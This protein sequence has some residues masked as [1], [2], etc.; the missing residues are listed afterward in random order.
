MYC[1][2]L[3]G[4]RKAVVLRRDRLAPY[5]PWA[6]AR[7]TCEQNSELLNTEGA[8]LK[9]TIFA[10]DQSPRSTQREANLPPLLRDFVVDV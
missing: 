8:S 1:V 10:Q 7:V 9:G 4:H 2:R 5:R 6:D 3:C